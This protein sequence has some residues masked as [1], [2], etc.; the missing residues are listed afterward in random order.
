LSIQ[1]TKAAVGR[2]SDQTPRAGGITVTSNTSKLR[3]L[4]RARIFLH[5]PAVY[6][7]LGARLVE[8]AGFEAAYV[9][10][11]VTGGSR[12]VTEPLL[13]MTE[14]VETA[15]AVAASVDIPVVVDAGAGFGEPLHS[16]RTVREFIHAGIAGIHVEDQLF[17]KR[18][19]YHK[20]QVHAVPTDEFV[21]KIAF[22]CRER[23]RVD[24]DFV[25]IA[26]TDTCRELG[27]EVAADRINRAADVG[28]D[29]GLLFPRNPDEAERAPKVCRLPLVYVMSRGNRDGRPIFTRRELEQIGYV[30][31]IEAQVVLLPAFRAIQTMLAELRSTG[32]Y[33]QMSEPEMVRARKDVEDLIRLEEYYAIEEET[34][35]HASAG[36]ATSP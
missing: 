29:L 21:T 16:M 10:G 5:M 34:V 20:Y 6:D 9:G 23:D 33:T 25:I 36:G 4:M 3:A 30:A 28:A 13:T 31:C 18:A 27:L 15:E 12:A 32:T 2:S 35:E 1:N 14:Q 24:R 7:P 11:Y 17:P 22:C 26:R 19:H 8:Q